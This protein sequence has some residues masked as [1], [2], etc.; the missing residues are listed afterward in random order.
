MSFKAVFTDMDG[1]LLAPN[2]QVSD[3]TKDVLKRLKAKGIPLILST[4]RP[5]SAVLHT[6]A[7]NGLEPD[8]VISTNGGRIHDRDQ[9]VVARHDL[10]PKLVKEIASIRR[11]PREDG[12]L[13]ETCP[14]KK[15][16]TN[17]YPERDWVTDDGDQQEVIEVFF[18][19]LYPKVV[20][21]LTCPDS[22]FDNVHQM[23]LK[24]PTDA[25]MAMKKYLDAHYGDRVQV[26]HSWITCIDVIQKSVDKGSAVS[27][28]CAMNGFKLEEVVAFGDSMNDEPMLKVVPHSFVMGN[29]LPALRE[30]LPDREVILSNAEDGLAKK[31]IE[32]FQL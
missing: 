13:D 11:Q 26:L 21:Y 20:D 16:S 8:Y 19:S 31:L 32:L 24:G 18:H 5:Y 23:W 12:S 9:N 17:I 29:A 15:F 25:L 28:V 4:A 22:T 3:F 10:D 1:T 30:A 27:E 7:T 6:I 2:H 14:P